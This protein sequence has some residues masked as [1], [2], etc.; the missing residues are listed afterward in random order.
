MHLWVF[1]LRAQQTKNPN[2]FTCSDIIWKVL[3]WKLKQF[4]KTENA[5]CIH[6]WCRSV[7]VG[8]PSILILINVQTDQ[9]SYGN[10]RNSIIYAIN[11]TVH[12]LRE[13]VQLQNKI[14][15][16][17]CIEGLRRLPLHI[18]YIYNFPDNRNLLQTNWLRK[19]KF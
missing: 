13:L 3:I 19:L 12:R 16:A 17:N 18:T 10:F 8:T 7:L 11:K 2:Q 15:G 14:N 6:L 9:T 1:I 5:V 4:T